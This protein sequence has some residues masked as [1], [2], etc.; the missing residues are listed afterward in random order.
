M[1]MMMLYSRNL[2]AGGVGQFIVWDNSCRLL[3]QAGEAS[4]YRILGDDEAGDNDKPAPVGTIGVCV[5]A[6]RTD[7]GAEVGGRH[8]G[9]SL[10]RPVG[11]QGLFWMWI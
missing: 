11:K 3:F 1:M 4:D 9:G 7:G 8:W 6:G 2:Q 10:C 5:K